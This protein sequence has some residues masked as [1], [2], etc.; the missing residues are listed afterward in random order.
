[1]K[2]KKK[3]CQSCG[4]EKDNIVFCENPYA[5]EINDDHTPGYYCEECLE[6]L[7]EDI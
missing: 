6:D 4:K 3:T 2:K 7:R 1:M 5:A